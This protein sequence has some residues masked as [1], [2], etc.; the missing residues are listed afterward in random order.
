LTTGV[1]VA[2]DLAFAIGAGVLLVTRLIVTRGVGSGFSA[3][4]GLA[5]RE[6]EATGR[7]TGVLGFGVV[8]A[9]RAGDTVGFCATR[10]GAERVSSDG[11]STGRVPTPLALERKPIFGRASTFGVSAGFGD[12]ATCAG[13]RDLS[14]CNRASGSADGAAACPSNEVPGSRNAKMKAPQKANLPVGWDTRLKI[15]AAYSR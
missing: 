12:G 5:E 15:G 11:I 2:G 9:M 8:A 14:H 10:F 6:V 7:G 1:G 13:K 3:R 4:A